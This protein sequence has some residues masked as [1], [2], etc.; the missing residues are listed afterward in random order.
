MLTPTASRLLASTPRRSPRLSPIPSPANHSTSSQH[1]MQAS[2]DFIAS[3]PSIHSTTNSSTS[4]QHTPIVSPMNQTSYF[5]AFPS[6]SLFQSASVPIWPEQHVSEAQSGQA[7]ASSSTNLHEE[8]VAAVSQE[9]ASVSLAAVESNG[10]QGDQRMD[11][12]SLRD[13]H[14]SEGEQAHPSLTT[15]ISP[16]APLE[17][18]ENMQP[19]AFPTTSNA[20][21]NPDLSSIFASPIPNMTQP[22]LSPLRLHQGFQSFALQPPPLPPNPDPS[23]FTT[24]L[25]S[26]D[27][28]DASIHANGNPRLSSLS[29]TQTSLLDRLMNPLAMVEAGQQTNIPSAPKKPNS[30]SRSNITNDGPANAGS[31]RGFMTPPSKVIIMEQMK[32]VSRAAMNTTPKKA[33]PAFSGSLVPPTVPNNLHPPFPVTPQQSNGMTRSFSAPSFISPTKQPDSSSVPGDNTPQPVAL[34][35]TT[36]STHTPSRIPVPHPTSASLETAPAQGSNALNGFGTSSMTV[37]SPSSSIQSPGSLLSPTIMSPGSS[38]LRQ[39]STLRSISSGGASKIPRPGKKPYSKPVSRLPKLPNKVA[40]VFPTVVP[41]KVNF[42]T[43]L[44]DSFY[45]NEI[46]K[47]PTA[48]AGSSFTNQDTARS[49]EC[50]E[51]P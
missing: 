8:T 26:S 39:P 11:D 29:P 32:G 1:P 9:G 4:V 10:Q 17:P 38:Q 36:P 37:T 22:V 15:S 24:P 46:H 25:P 34:K 50:S 49:T 23:S 13:T 51:Y 19:L 35:S 28:A 3:I 21:S 44:T 27:R 7:E 42:S 43:V 47:G 6:P 18:G 2:S 30:I 40:S 41:P 20:S 33:L 45:A 5:P 48:T 16:E 12:A 31:T 14:M